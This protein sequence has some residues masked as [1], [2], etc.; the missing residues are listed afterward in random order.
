[1]KVILSFIFVML[2]VAI[3]WFGAAVGM[4]YFFG[5]IFPYFAIALFLVGV[6]W[7]IYSWASSPVP[8]R[9]CTTCGQQKSLPWIKSST[10]EAPHN[11]W[12]VIRRMF[13]E[14]V[15][16][17]SLFRNT[18]FELRKGPRLVY[19]SS[20]WLWM[21]SLAFHY[22]F[23]AI[24]IRHLRF[25]TEP[26]PGFVRLT[27]SLDSFFQIWLP[28]IYLSDVIIVV[29]LGYLLVRRL[30]DKKLNYLSMVGD[31][32]PLFLLLGIV[33]TGFMLRY[34]AKT[35]IV[36]IKEL[37][38]GLIT[39]APVVP[40]GIGVTF[41]VHMFLVCVLFAYF[42]FSKLMHFAGVFFSPTRNL[43]N[44]NRAKRH[45]NPWDYPVKVHTYEEYED[46]FRDVM[47]AADMP[48]DKE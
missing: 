3:A 42:P 45:V 35:D 12:G 20:K 4:E 41:F 32:F 14:V 13:L 15:L 44:N 29:A 10:L 8:F 34:F 43:A 21:F 38:M 46:E 36:A 22:T 24:F 31:Y 37:S 5:V 18:K 47:K 2:L 6:I 27:E 16:F 33:I 28:I 19:G 39:L 9:I 48:L 17:R 1:M 7:R 30:V 23:L 40:D 11:A 25:F 26:V